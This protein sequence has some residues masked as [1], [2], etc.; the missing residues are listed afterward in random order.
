M[1]R[2]HF[3]VNPQIIGADSQALSGCL[4][5]C[6]G[7]SLTGS[8][9]TEL[10]VRW[11]DFIVRAFLGNRSVTGSLCNSLSHTCSSSYS[12]SSTRNHQRHFDNSVDWCIST[13]FP[14]VQSSTCTARLTARMEYKRFSIHAFEREPGRWRVRISRRS[15]RPL[16]AT[17]RAKLQVFVTEMDSTSA[18]AAIMFAMAAIDAGMFFRKTNRSTEK[19]WRP[20]GR[21]PVR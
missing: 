19:Y 10:S 17:H 14:A 8:S 11:R 4:I 3:G 9:T 15:G 20:R 1:R 5:Y 18:G 2:L 6:L 21:K 7:R 16:I 13:R 12:P